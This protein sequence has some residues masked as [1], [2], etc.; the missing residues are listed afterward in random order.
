MYSEHR[1]QSV[2]PQCSKP[3]RRIRRTPVDRLLSLFAPRKRYRCRTWGCGWEGTI[4]DEAATPVN[5]ASG[6]LPRNPAKR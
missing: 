3:L 5:P 6:P 2:Y 1:E 4:R